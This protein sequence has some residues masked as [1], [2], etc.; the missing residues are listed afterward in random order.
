MEVLPWEDDLGD[1]GAQARRPS[2]SLGTRHFV[3]NPISVCLDLSLQFDGSRY[4]IGS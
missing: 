2:V 4:I 3:D 1:L